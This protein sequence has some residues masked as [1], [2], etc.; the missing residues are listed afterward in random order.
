MSYA[1]ASRI[2]GRER[3]E[4]SVLALELGGSYC[5]VVADGLGGHGFGDEASRLLVEA[6]AREFDGAADNREFLAHAFDRA[7]ECILSSQEARGLNNQMK[8]TAVALS[9]IG[10]KCAW[11][12]VGDSRLYRFRRG[13]LVGRTLDHSVTQM[14][15]LAGEI[16]EREIAAHPDRARLMR[17]VGDRWSGPQ[18]E[19]SKEARLHR[20]TEFMLC[21]D[22][23]WERVPPEGLAPPPGADAAGWLSAALA[24]AEGAGQS[25]GQGAGQSAGQGAGIMDNYSAVVVIVE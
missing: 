21:S 15:A 24:A 10:G 12:H 3:N 5:F 14:L 1:S 23:L 9:F 17:A 8:T 7:Q 20:H 2:G 6:F 4:D 19:I 11:G 16:S 13:A 25:A 22:G 18:Y